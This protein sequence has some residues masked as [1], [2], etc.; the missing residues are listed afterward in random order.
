MVRGL[1]FFLGCV[2]LAACASV[3]TGG[4]VPS[5]GAALNP[6]RVHAISLPDGDTNSGILT[7]ALVVGIV[8]DICLPD[9]FE[10]EFDF[11]EVASATGAQRIDNPIYPTRVHEGDF[12]PEAWTSPQ[13][14]RLFFFQTKE[15]GAGALGGCT[16]GVFD[17][18]M[19]LAIMSFVVALNNGFGTYTGETL[20]FDVVSS[21]DPEL[22]Y[23]RLQERALLDGFVTVKS[24]QRLIRLLTTAEVFD[25]ASDASGKHTGALFSVISMTPLWVEA[26]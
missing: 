26:N 25:D 10:D 6:D 4:A 7:P 19:D 11:D 13:A 24:P 22:S 15:A 17:G 12:P 2:F 18:D 14:P 9:V 1:F 16:I 21:Q 23:E 3:E 5:G 8:E 20:G